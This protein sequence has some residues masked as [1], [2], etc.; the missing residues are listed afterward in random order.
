MNP[1]TGPAIREATDADF[2]IIAAL[3]RR[4]W[5]AC[6]GDMISPGQ[7]EYML[8][9]RYTPEG[10]LAATAEG[11]M[12]YLL[13][14]FDGTPA[15]FAADGPGASP[16]E[17]KLHQIYVIP[18]RQRA[19]VGRALMGAVAERARRHGAMT[20]ALTVNRRNERA[21][22]IYERAGFTIR[23]A[24]VFDIGGGFVMDDYVMAKPLTPESPAIPSTAPAPGHGG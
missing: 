19:G 17:W 22:R 9:I 24:K 1:P 20:I 23:E 11:R 5:Q 13:A 10:M 12:T 2:P 21:R 3:A 7:I 4:I 16:G 6:F 8:G 14:E 15:G 18:E